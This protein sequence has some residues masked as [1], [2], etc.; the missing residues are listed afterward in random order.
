LSQ[1]YFELKKDNIFVLAEAPGGIYNAS[2]IR[3]ICDT[4]ESFSLFLKVTE[5]QRIGFIVQK[6]KLLDLS[7]KFEKSGLLL[8]HYQ[9]DFVLSPRACLGE[10]CSHCEQDALG[11]ALELSPVLNEKYKN[12]FQSFSL[13]LNGC[14]RACVGFDDVSL[15]GGKAGYH[16]FVGGKTG[17]S[18]FEHL[19]TSQEIPKEKISE[20]VLSVLEI[21]SLQKQEGESLRELINRVGFEAF[22]EQALKLAQL[23]GLS[24]TSSSHEALQNPAAQEISSTPA[25][26]EA[27]FSEDLKIEN[28]R[29]TEK[30]VS[31][32]EGGTTLTTHNLEEPQPIDH[33]FGEGEETVSQKLHDTAL[34]ENEGVESVFHDVGSL[35]SGALGSVKKTFIQVRGSYLTI[36]LSDSTN[37]HIPFKGIEEGKVIEVQVEDEVFLIEN[38]HGKLQVQYGGFKMHIPTNHGAFGLGEEEG[39]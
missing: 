32:L 28:I 19:L 8:K 7:Q 34:P 15:V 31:S 39:S 21:Y 13:T 30:Q 38:T 37:F 6:E 1:E 22:Q 24:Q 18:R 3:F 12:T 23:D 17:H 2:Q 27:I 35:A 16:I 5:D 10:L 33:G 25:E 29:F 26:E 11:H 36:V 4:A 20:A 14:D 9:N